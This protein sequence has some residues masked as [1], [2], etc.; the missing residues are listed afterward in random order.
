MREESRR[1]NVWLASYPKSGNTWMRLVLTSLRKGGK[2]VDINRLADGGEGSLLSARSLF[3]RLLDVESSDLSPDEAFQLRPRLWDVAEWGGTPQT[4]WKVHD[5]WERNAD[6]QPLF[7]PAV[8]AASLYLVRDPRDVAVSWAHHRNCDIDSAIAIM[9]DKDCWGARKAGRMTLQL[10]QH[11]SSW[12]DHVESWLFRSG[13]DPLV[14]RY[15]EMAADLAA[16]LR[17]VTVALGWSCTPDAIAAAV[18]ATRF[19]RLR[20]QEQREG[21]IERS[22]HAATFFRRGVAGGWRDVLTPDQAARI[23]RDHEA[24]MAR[25]GYL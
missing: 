18:A 19:E 15:E 23:E 21:F 12:S 17:T 22:P 2:A 24:V 25:L 11:Y 8:T 10:P 9:A 13:L 7:P 14:I 3:D 1:R 16:V 20:E 6:N 5:I 4:I